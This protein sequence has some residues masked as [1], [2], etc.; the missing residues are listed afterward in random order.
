MLLSSQVNS[1]ALSAISSSVSLAER[2]K[3]LRK[4]GKELLFFFF[5]FH[6]MPCMMEGDQ[7]F[8]DKLHLYEYIHGML[9][10]QELEFHLHNT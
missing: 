3:I 7:G 8:C 2:A 6:L 4:L 1:A 5:A 10:K 9:R